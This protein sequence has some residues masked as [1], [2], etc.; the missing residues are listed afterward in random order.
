M[1]AVK[2][3]VLKKRPALQLTADDFEL[4]TSTLRE[5]KDGEFL[6]R[7]SFLSLDAGF[8]QWMNEGASD[9]YLQAM[10][11]GQP[12]QSIVLGVVESSKNPAYPTGA[13][14][15]GRTSWET[16]SIADGSDLMTII[17]PEKDIPL[18]EY[19]A[20]LGPSGMTAYFGL[21][22]I[23]QP[24]PEDTILVSAAAGGVGSLVG[25]MAKTV[26]CT[27]I[28]ISSSNEKCQWLQESLHYDHVINY[29]APGGLD[30]GLSTIAPGG[31]DIYF[32]N[33]GGKMLDTAM[34]HLRMN[35][36][37]VLCGAIAQYES[38]Q[39]E[40]VYNL[41]ELITKRAKAEGF[42]F[43]DY[44]DRYGEAT[45]KLAGWIRE[46]KLSSPL[47]ISEGIESTG[48]AFCDMLQGRNLGKSLVRL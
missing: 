3:I 2:H 11:L 19:L 14:V 6:I 35:A 23:G 32:D 48:A 1:T 7:N 45:Q 13:C 30:A 21:F 29:R 40:G 20:A 24:K 28:G 12:V 38:A 26:G 8:R 39:R 18:E 10:P 37:L 36:R 33:V 46:G 16:H 15:M 27:T 47:N 31:I 42:M 43:S 34:T 17:E 41:W 25:Q 5:L 9:N 4:T 44:V 22:D